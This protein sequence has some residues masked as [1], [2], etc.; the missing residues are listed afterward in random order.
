MPSLTKWSTLWQTCARTSRTAMGS[1]VA[2]KIFIIL[3]KNLLYGKMSDVKNCLYL[4]ESF[5]WEN[6]VTLIIGAN[7]D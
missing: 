7:Y 6:E 4:N 1:E 5:M 2:S 3:N